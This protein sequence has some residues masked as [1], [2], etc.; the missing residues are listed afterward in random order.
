[1]APQISAILKAYE[2]RPELV[3][4]IDKLSCCSSRRGLPAKDIIDVDLVVLD[5][6]KEAAYV[7][8][9]ESVGFGRLPSVNRTGIST[10]SSTPRCPP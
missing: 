8:K 3:E 10:P 5:S 9:L 2:Y 7:E 6:V 4:R 1:M